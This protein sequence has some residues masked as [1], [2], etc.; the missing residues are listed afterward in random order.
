ELLQSYG[1]L[2]D[3]LANIEQ[4]KGAKRKENLQ[5]HAEDARI[6]KQLATV[7]RAVAV[8]VDIAA[9]STREPD[10]SRVREVF[11]E[12]E[13]RDPLRRLEEA[14]GDPDVAAP[15]GAAAGRRR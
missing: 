14:L 9:E 1:T 8:E 7:Q 13:L 11:R 6:S 4:I 15:A 5:T 10:R 3:V 2:E 12:Y